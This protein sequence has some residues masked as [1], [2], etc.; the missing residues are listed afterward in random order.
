MTTRDHSGT[1]CG[2]LPVI[3]YRFQDLPKS[4]QAYYKNLAEDQHNAD[5]ASLILAFEVEWIALVPEAYPSHVANIGWLQTSGFDKSTAS[6]L[7]LKNEFVKIGETSYM[8]ALGIS[9]IKVY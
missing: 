3:V 8:I 4:T 1:F 7:W 2:M 9:E 5:C 6:P